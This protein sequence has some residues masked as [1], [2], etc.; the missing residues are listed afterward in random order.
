MMPSMQKS[1]QNKAVKAV[2]APL[3]YA[4]EDRTNEADAGMPEKRPQNMFAKPRLRTIWLMRAICPERAESVLRM[5]V[6][7]IRQTKLNAKAVSAIIFILSR[8]KL[9]QVLCHV[10][11]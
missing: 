6:P 8:L 7:S 4:V 10:P 1:P 5:L 2:L 9:C 11:F 3:V